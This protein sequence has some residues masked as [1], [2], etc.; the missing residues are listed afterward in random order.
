M[1]RAC[2]QAERAYGSGVVRRLQYLDLINDP[3]PT[4][5]GLLG[6]LNEPYEAACLEPL[7]IRINSSNVP[8]DFDSSDPE[9]NK[10]VVDEAHNLEAELM[11]NPGPFEPCP[12]VSN[13]LERMFEERVR[14]TWNIGP[15]FRKSLERIAELER[16]VGELKTRLPSVMQN[17]S[18]A[19]SPAKESAPFQRRLRRVLERFRGRS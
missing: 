14:H 1:V 12:A 5:R 18:T 15:N 7:R 16:Q 4:I 3:E 9:T 8:S 19:S 13:E 17:L 6:F 10:A 2:F 11:Q